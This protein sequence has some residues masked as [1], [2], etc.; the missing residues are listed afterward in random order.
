MA[1]E[2]VIY[3]HPVSLYDA[4]A[5][6]ANAFHSALVISHNS[7]SSRPEMNCF[8]RH[9]PGAYRYGAKSFRPVI[10]AGLRRAQHL[11]VK[12]I[13][14]KSVTRRQASVI[15]PWRCQRGSSQ[16]P[17]LLSTSSESV[18]RPMTLSGA[19]LRRRVQNQ[20]VPLAAAGKATLLTKRDAPS[21]G[22]GHGKPAAR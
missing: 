19:V 8:S 1:S 14:P 3:Q 5:C 9:Q 6:A 17:R 11:P 12:R 20:P 18:I 21:S 22:K 16:N 4:G 7:A 10:I 2:Y 15:N 13:K